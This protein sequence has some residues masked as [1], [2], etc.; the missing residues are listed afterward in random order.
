MAGRS[1]AAV[2]SG[3]APSDAAPANVAVKARVPDL[4]IVPRFWASSSRDMPIPSSAMV[5]VRAG[6]SGV[7][8]MAGGLAEANAALVNASKRRRSVASAALATSSRRK[9]SRSE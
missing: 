8:R 4:A 6:L 1:S 5:S 7:M 2:A 9:I 3:L